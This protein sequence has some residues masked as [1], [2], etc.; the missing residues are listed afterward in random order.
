MKIIVTF[1][2]TNKILQKNILFLRNSQLSNGNLV[3]L[4]R[5]YH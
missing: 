2:E 5:I 3:F 4:H 1:V